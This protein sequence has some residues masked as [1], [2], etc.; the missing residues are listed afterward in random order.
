MN[1]QVGKKIS[2]IISANDFQLRNEK[3]N[4][5]SKPMFIK[6]LFYSLESALNILNKIFPPHYVPIK[7]RKTKYFNHSELFHNL[8]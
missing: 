6:T 7:N 5:I 4:P 2:C 8:A 3:K 1:I